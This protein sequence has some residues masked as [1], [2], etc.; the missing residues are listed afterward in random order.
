M[1]GPAPDTETLLDDARML[2]RGVENPRVAS[3]LLMFAE[4]VRQLQERLDALE[5]RLAA[6]ESRP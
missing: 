1:P 5:S 6:R 4:L 3:A 2:A